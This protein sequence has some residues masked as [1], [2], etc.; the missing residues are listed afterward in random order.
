[1]GLKRKY[2]YSDANIDS[3]D[4]IQLNLLYQQAKEAILNGTHPVNLENAVNFAA[5]QCQVQFG[6]HKESTHKAGFIDL[7]EFL[8]QAYVRANRIER[9]IFQ[10][11]KALLGMSE[12]FSFQ[13]DWLLR[14]L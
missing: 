9:K 11:H 3:R 1:M 13:F 4:P 2:F 6:D 8:P 10:E 14:K 12:I 7:K 5:L